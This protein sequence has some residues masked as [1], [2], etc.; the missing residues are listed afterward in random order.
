MVDLQDTIMKSPSKTD[1]SGEPSTKKGIGKPKK[2][3]DAETA[4]KEK[5]K[6]EKK[7]AKVE[8]EK[9][10]AEVRHIYAIAGSPFAYC[11]ST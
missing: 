11:Y 10:V 8:K 5:E 2:V 1:K 3:V 7:M 6:Q 4:A 9:K